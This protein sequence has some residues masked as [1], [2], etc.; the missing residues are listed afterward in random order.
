MAIL[1]VGMLSGFRFPAVDGAPTELIRRVEI[2]PERVI[3]YLDSVS[4]P[5]PHRFMS[6]ERVTI[7]GKIKL[8]WNSTKWVRDEG[9]LLVN[10][11]ISGNHDETA[12]LYKL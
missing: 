6:E 5:S 11:G 1:D 10:E 12:T 3:F 4:L 7:N 8:S 2:Q 9:C